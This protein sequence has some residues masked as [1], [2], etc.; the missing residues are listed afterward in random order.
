MADK[1]LL[2]VTAGPSYDSGTHQIVAVN[3]PQLTHISSSLGT[4]SLSVRIQNYRGLPRNSPSTSPYFSDPTHVH[5]QY[6]IS[7]RLVPHIAIPGPALVFGNDFDSPIRDRLPPGFGTALR[8]VKWAIDPGID[9]DVYGD[10]PYL[11]GNAL[12][13]VN[14]LRVGGKEDEEGKGKG[15]D[16][17]G[18]EEKGEDP[19]RSIEEGGEGGGEKL[20]EEL[21]VPADA[22]QRKKWFLAKG[23]TEDWVWEKD[24]VYWCDFFNPYVDFNHTGDVYFVVLFS[25]IPRHIVQS[26]EE[27]KE[28]AEKEKKGN[29]ELD[30]KDNEKENGKWKEEA[31]KIEGKN[32]KEEDN[33]KRDRKEMKF[34]PKEEDLD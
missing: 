22:D 2:R 5:D 26:E 3:T 23:R 33:D 25:L 10:K 7:F 18:K 32:E 19:Q 11:Y 34:E 4:V 30:K 8:I 1:Y 17:V 6:S 20:R 31:D 16:R 29:D 27:A 24:R 21:G 12:S 9:G 28:Q 14:V 15:G 13:S